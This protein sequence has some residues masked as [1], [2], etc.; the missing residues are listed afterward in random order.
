MAEP[1]KE[2]CDILIVCDPHVIIVSV[3]DIQLNREKEAAGYDRW[4]RKAVDGSVKQI[5]GAERSLVT[6]PHVIRKD[7]TPGL[8]LPALAL[9]K[10]H[11]IAVA[12]GSGGE[13][14]ITSGDF[15]KGF[16]HVMDE[17]SFFQLLTELDT[18]TD[19]ADYL[20][21]KEGLLAKSAVVVEGVESNLLGWYLSHGR[22]FPQNP[23]MMVFDNTIWKGLCDNPEFQRR[24]Q[25]DAD[26]YVWDRLIE[27]LADTSAKP[28]NGPAPTLNDLDLALREM[29]RETRF[30]RR[31]LGRD[32]REFLEKA[33]AKIV[34]SRMIIT[35]RG[36]IYVFVFFSAGEP[37]MARIAELAARCCAAR[38]RAGRGD[39]VIGVGIG[40]FQAGAGSTSDIVHIKMDD[41]STVENDD[42]LRG[43][44]YFSKSPMQNVHEDEY[45]WKSDA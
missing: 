13:V 6:A 19:L 10:T 27:A 8:A 37:D 24:K 41:W 32:F 7:G 42:T 29:A 45:P 1:G 33:N 5:Y 43:F 35:E 11:R 4:L 39:V 23:D 9:R 44:A 22:S 25:A 16:V 26:S 2:L 28:M 12:F 40:E 18:I 21:A 17:H 36:I 3:K 15:G 31:V 38:Q 20:G 30:H 14:P 34:H